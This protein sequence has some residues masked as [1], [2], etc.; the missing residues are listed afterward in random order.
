MATDFTINAHI[1]F[2]K[3]QEQNRERKKRMV[4]ISHYTHNR[5]DTS[6]TNIWNSIAKPTP[7]KSEN[8]NMNN[9]KEMVFSKQ[10]FNQAL[11]VVKTCWLARF[12]ICF[13]AIRACLKFCLSKSWR[14]RSR[15]SS[16]V[17][18]WRKECHRLAVS[19]FF[20]KWYF[21]NHCTASCYS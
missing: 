17:F 21:T 11:V 13:T 3:R 20:L 7:N 12:L 2:W 6:F 19:F 18:I 14:L 15:K 4:T 10:N 5:T 9:E 8:E 1:T 16:S